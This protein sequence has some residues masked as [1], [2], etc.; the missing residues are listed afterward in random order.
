[1]AVRHRDPEVTKASLLEAAAELI[2]KRGYDGTTTDA[3]AKRAGVNK[4]MINYHFGG[5]KGLYTTLLTDVLSGMANRLEAVR[6]WDAPPDQRLTAFIA[7]FR[8][9][10]RMQPAAPP[11][12]LREAISGGRNLDS[13]VFQSFLRIFTVLQEILEQ[14]TREGKFRPVNPVLTQ[15]GL[16]GSLYFFFSTEAFRARMVRETGLDAGPMEPEE[17]IRH[18]REM[19]L[20]GLAP[21][22]SNTSPTRPEGDIR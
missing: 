3:I 22:T 17:Y 13:K 19:L 20:G 14:G 8:E 21:R 16:V 4:A 15:I 1:V 5:K 9:T 2:S 7:A 12:L 10:I 18:W 6:G 11:I